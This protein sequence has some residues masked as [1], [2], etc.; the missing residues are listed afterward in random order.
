VIAVPTQA[1]QDVADELVEAGVRALFNYSEALLEVPG[2]V[3]VRTLS[4]AAE[5]LSMLSRS[6]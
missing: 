1:A 4:P 2:N 6:A 5:L 3:S